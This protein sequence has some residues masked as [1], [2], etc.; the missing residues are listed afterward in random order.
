MNNREKCISVIDSFTEGQLA[1]ILS[2]LTSARA[3]AD[4]TADEAYRM[5]LYTDYQNS[6]DKVEPSDIEDFAKMLGVTF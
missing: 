3:L 6:P 1:S 4:E 2:M 5:S